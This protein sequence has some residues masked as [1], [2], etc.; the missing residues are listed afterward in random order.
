M[1]CY[2]AKLVNPQDMFLVAY[3][4]GNS[5]MLMLYS[6]LHQL[7][8][9]QSNL[10]GAEAPIKIPLFGVNQTHV[11]IKTKLSFLIGFTRPTAVRS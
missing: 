3:P 9:T 5:K 7:N 8:N 2:T 4:T 1:A 11:N 10:Y 6:G